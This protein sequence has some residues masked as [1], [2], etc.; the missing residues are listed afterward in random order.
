MTHDEFGA[1]PRGINHIGMTVPDLDQASAFLKQALGA[2][3]AY[4]GLTRDDPPRE[5][6]EVER[7]L[8]LPKGAR[9]IRQRMLRIGNGP[10]LEIFEIES[11]THQPAAGLHDYGLN[12][13][14]V[15]VDDMQGSVRR[16]AAAGGRLLSEVHGNSRHEDTPG[17][18]SVY[19]IT[20]WGGLIELQTIPGG[21]YYPDDSE[22]EVW[23]P[24]P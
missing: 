10:G 8:G 21:F 14:A 22:T 4:D 19:A 16:M 18:G 6:P 15:Y 9:I 12:H 24:T 5:G 20:P 7:Q 2:R 3:W 23:L 17:N 1:L 13:I 11:P